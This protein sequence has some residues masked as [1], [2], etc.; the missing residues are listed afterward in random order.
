[1]F[2]MASKWQTSAVK[3]VSIGLLTWIDVVEAMLWQVVE[4]R[5]KMTEPEI[6]G[7]TER[8]T[9]A[10][11]T[12]VEGLIRDMLIANAPGRRPCRSRRASSSFYTNCA[13]RARVREGEKRYSEKE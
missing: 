5:R 1:M 9:R 10:L 6:R 2:V 8:P 13:Y 7:V 12:S 11:K 3:A 4:S